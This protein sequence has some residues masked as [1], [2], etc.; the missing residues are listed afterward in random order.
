MADRPNAEHDAAAATLVYCRDDDPGIRRIRAGKGFRYRMPDGG[1]PDPQTRQRIRKLAIPP[2]WTDV[3]IA[4][5][6]N[7][8]MQATGRDARGRKQ[9]RYHKDWIALRGENK[10]ST[11]IAFAEVLPALR[12]SIDA[13]I[14][15]PGMGRAKVLASVVRL[16]DRTLV[17]IGNEDY[18][19]AN[20]SF[21]LTTLH[22]RHAD[23]SPRYMLKLSFRGKAGKDWDIRIDDP[24]LARIV[25]GSRDLPGQHLF[26]YV[27]DDGITRHAITSEDVNSYIRDRSDSTFTSKHFRTW[28][29]TVMA[30][31]WL[32]KRPLPARQKEM[33]TTRNEVIDAVA[34]RLGN[35]RVICRNSYIHPDVVAAWEAGRFP[36][37][38]RKARRLAGNSKYLSRDEAV[39]LAI[40]RIL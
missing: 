5:P 21:G 31:V 30:T 24:R 27:G 4:S 28:G 18:A 7:G 10:F 12:R 33:V 22:D 36:A 26:Q 35:T 1:S 13:D 32:A 23:I 37:L 11:L 34:G 15:S 39:T 17:R 29:A 8:H 6:A 16:L 9:Y 40:L 2:A 20:G 3:W 25:K 19:R 38:L 14:A